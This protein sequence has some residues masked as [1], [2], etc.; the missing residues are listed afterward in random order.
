MD[1]LDKVFIWLG[2]TDKSQQQLED[3]FRLDYSV[4]GNFDDPTYKI[5]GFCKDIGEKWYN[6]DFVGYLKFKNSLS[7]QEILKHIP[8]ALHESKKIMSICREMGIVKVNCS[9][10][11]SGEIKIPSRHKSY[12]G[13]NFIGEFDLD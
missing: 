8:V 11:Y 12:N 4:E 10:W 9:Y 5:C 1:Y 7:I 6:E 3:Y 13:I 2:E